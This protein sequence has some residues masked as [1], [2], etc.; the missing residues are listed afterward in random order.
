MTA[1]QWNEGNIAAALARATF[2]GHLC[3]LPNCTWTGN[4]V[5]LL[6]VSKCLRVID[7]EVKISRADLRADIKKQKWWQTPSWAARR[8]GEAAERLEWPRK[9][10]KHYYAMP[11]EIWREELVND[12]PA[13]SGVL[14]VERVEQK[15]W[16][17]TTRVEC[18]RRSRPNRDA[19][20]LSAQHLQQVARLTSLRL[21][22]AY[23]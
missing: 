11:R 7:V 13:V 18:R 6:V 8:Q 17:P 15:P 16:P 10:W 12:I 19:P 4:E 1:W 20:R 22:D 23:K 14:L 3:C 2:D 5:D 21:W 9:V